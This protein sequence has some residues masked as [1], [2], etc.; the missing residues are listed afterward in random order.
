MRDVTFKEMGRSIM[1]EIGVY[2]VGNGQI[3]SESSHYNLP[4][5]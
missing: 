4:Q 2:Q 5:F 1:S 3:I